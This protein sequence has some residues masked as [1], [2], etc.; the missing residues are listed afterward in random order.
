VIRAIKMLFLL[1][2]G[3]EEDLIPFNLVMEAGNR[4]FS[5]KLNSARSKKRIS[6]LFQRVKNLKMM[7]LILMLSS[8]T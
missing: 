8:M 7:A 2:V 1:L 5:N 3:I 6:I 4:A